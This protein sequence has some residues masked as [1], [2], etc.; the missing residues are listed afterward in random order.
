M[1]NDSLP[2]FEQES[3][4]VIEKQETS[5]TSSEGNVEV[6]VKYLSVLGAATMIATWNT[7]ST[8][9]NFPNIFGQLGYIGGP[10]FT[11]FLQGMAYYVCL[12]QITLIEHFKDL[13]YTVETFSDLGECLMGKWGRKIFMTI[14]MANQIGFLPYA[15][16]LTVHS[17]Q[18][19]FP[20][21]SFLSCNGTLMALVIGVCYILIQTSRD[22]K[23]FNWLAYVIFFLTIVQAGIFASHAIENRGE[24]YGPTGIAFFGQDF[25]LPDNCTLPSDNSPCL[26][27]SEF[28]TFNTFWTALGAIVFSFAP[29][30]IVTELMSEMQN[31]GKDTKQALTIAF[32]FSTFMNE[33]MGFTYIMCLGYQVPMQVQNLL[34]LSSVKSI[35]S[36]LIII[37]AM[38][39]DFVIS[40]LVINR[41]VVLH[42]YPNFD[43]KWT[44]AN[45]ITWA[46]ATF[47]PMTLT[48]LLALFVPKFDSLITFVTAFSIP[49]A[50]YV[51][52]GLFSFHALSKRGVS[53]VEIPMTNIKKIVL[54]IAMLI[55]FT[56]SIVKFYQ[57][58]L[59]LTELD[60]AGDYWCEQIAS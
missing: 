26:T 39:L 34:P 27:P 32:S 43:F 13:G 38:I 51:L 20:H 15:L 30:F 23:H 56:V 5:S 4:N 45:A 28:Y 35:I 14:Q 2:Q 18:N 24:T 29:S 1:L 19:I 57:F 10:F 48:F 33:F 47:V 46:G 50:N 55:G 59:D 17:I 40:V 22:W 41:Q 3:K 53:E 58:I 11:L 12:H 60:F 9:M 44:K 7:T 42:F 49:Y 6:K 36:Q 37:F 16:D 31:P 54:V 25:T 8:L 52:A 21:N